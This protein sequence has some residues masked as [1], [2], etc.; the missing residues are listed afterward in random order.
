MRSLLLST[1]L[2]A[3]CD[4]ADP[5]AGL[6][7]EV[8]G[9]ESSLIY[10]TDNRQDYYQVTGAGIRAAAD[11]VVMQVDRSYL[12]RNGNGWD[13]DTSYSYGDYNDLCRNEPY[14]SQPTVGDCSGVLVGPDLVATAGHCIDSGSCSRTR[15]VFGFR[16]DGANNVRDTLDAQDVYS[17]SSIVARSTGSAD[18]AIVRLDRTVT[19]RNP[20]RVRRSGT[21]GTGTG[22]GLIG[23]PY[24]IPVKIA[25]GAQVRENSNNNWFGANLDAYGGNSGSPVFNVTN[26]VLEGLLVRGNDDFV[27]SGNCYVSNTC[28]DAQGCPSFEEVTRATRFQ[29]YIP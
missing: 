15:Y 29:S 16:M 6:A 13:L 27:R 18:Y 14:Y 25:A 26:G 11:A 10:G 23:H 24:G 5:D 28:S 4:A 19:G 21:I 1:M 22:V 9:D 2:L 7:P 8:E 17:C 3:A 12:T 20:V